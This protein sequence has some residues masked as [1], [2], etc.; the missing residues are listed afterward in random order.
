MS[1]SEFLTKVFRWAD[2]LQFEGRK[3]DLA[4]MSRNALM[5][6]AS[7]YR[8]YYDG[9]DDAL[10]KMFGALADMLYTIERDVRRGDA[11]R[12]VR[13]IQGLCLKAQQRIAR[14]GTRDSRAVRAMD[15]MANKMAASSR[16]EGQI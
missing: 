11:A 7:H 8:L 1:A 16:N 2:G 15:A 6:K 9:R 13:K 4:L 3:S 14:I 10:S 12:A 5:S